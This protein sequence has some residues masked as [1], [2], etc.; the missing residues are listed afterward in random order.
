MLMGLLSRF[1][2]IL[3]CLVIRRMQS[4]VTWFQMRVVN[5]P[6]HYEMKREL[7]S[8]R[9]SQSPPFLSNMNLTDHYLSVSG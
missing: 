5:M 7:S 4:T 1:K 9:K 2:E 3:K 6:P 8:S